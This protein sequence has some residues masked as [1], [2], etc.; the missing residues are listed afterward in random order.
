MKADEKIL[1]IIEDHANI[2]HAIDS[3][4]CSI[5]NGTEMPNYIPVLNDLM[6]TD[7]LSLINETIKKLRQKLM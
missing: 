4:C 3:I 6:I 2:V 7:Q 5:E 1:N